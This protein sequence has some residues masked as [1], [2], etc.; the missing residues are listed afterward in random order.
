MGSEEVFRCKYCGAPL[1]VSP[2]TIVAICNYC[3][4][5]NWIKG[6]GR[7]LIARPASENEA[8]EKARR[9]VGESFRNTVKTPLQVF[10][11]Y[12]VATAIADADY[13]AKTIVTVERCVSKK[14][15]DGTT[16]EE[17][18]TRDIPVYVKGYL[19]GFS[20][21]YSVPAR[22]GIGGKTV[23]A[24]GR[25][26]L[27]SN[28]QLVELASF[29]FEREK[30]SYRNIL[31]VELDKNDVSELI[32]DQHLDE[33]RRKVIEEIKEEARAKASIHGSPVS[34]SIVWKRITPLNIR[35]EV[36]DP[37]LTPAYYVRYG[38]QGEYKILLSG[39]DLKELVVEKPVSRMERVLWG[40]A[41]AMSSGLAGGA[42]ARLLMSQAVTQGLFI[43]LLSAIIIVAG[44]GYGAYYSIRKMFRPVGVSIK[45]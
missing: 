38:E 27:R 18:Y 7:V 23:E 45:V 9:L 31:A 16:V 20:N 26:L 4:R 5:E 12:Y 2:E 30:A 10:I 15:K 36:S 32:L 29:E 8:L 42:V 6:S 41:A 44:G 28:I 3:G 40:V 19:E 21:K 33:L 1:E 11:P 25:Y 22:K 43:V 39:F 35:I 24:L 37:I 17:C 13:E 14:K 34:V